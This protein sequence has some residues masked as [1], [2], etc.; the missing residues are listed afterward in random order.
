MKGGHTQLIPPQKRNRTL[1]PMV[2]FSKSF[3]C[4]PEFFCGK[5]VGWFLTPSLPPPP[6]PFPRSSSVFYM[7]EQYVTRGGGGS[8]LFLGG[9]THKNKVW[10]VSSVYSKSYFCFSK[11]RL[12]LLILVVFLSAAWGWLRRIRRSMRYG[13]L[14]TK[15]RGWW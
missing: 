8:T 1:E 3:F 4:I 9:H 12:L 10:K 5:S 2:W 13:S 7:N 14:E 15:S 11:N 6:P